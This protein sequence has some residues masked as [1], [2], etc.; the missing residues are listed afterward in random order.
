MSRK[1]FI[2]GAI[3]LMAA[4]LVVRLLGFV[5]RIYLSNLIGAEGM[6]IF[7]LISPVYS[8]VILTLTA[9][10]SI[11]VSRMVSAELARGHQVNLRRVAYC[12]LVIVGI[13]GLFTAALIYF[14]LD[15]LVNHVI[16]DRRTY[17]SFLLLIPCIPVIACASALKGYFY[18]IGSVVP[19]AVS[20]I[21]EQI[22]KIGFVML[23]AGYFVNAGLEY[24]CAIATVGMAFGE[25]S[26]LAVLAIVYAAGRNRKTD[27]K[28]E[29]GLMRKRKIVIE[30]VKTSVPVS[31]NR[32]VVS[33]MSA[34]ENILIPAM[35]LTGGLDY[36]SS[37]EVYGRLTGMAMP[38]IFFPALV[39]SSL[40]TTLVPAIAEA[41]SLRDFKTA[42]YRIS[43]CIQITFVLGFIFTA[44]FMSYPNE[45]GNLI[46]RREKIG[47]LLQVLSY[48][49]VLI[50]LQQ[51]LTGVLNGLGKQG[52]LLANTLVGS[53]IRIAFVYFLIP[54]YGIKSYVW[55]IAVS[56]F[57]TDILNLFAVTKVTGLLLNVR[58][59]LLGPA[60]VGIFMI[61][62]GRYI[63]YL[64]DIFV[65]SSIII[66]LLSLASSIVIGMLLMIAVGAVDFKDLK[67]KNR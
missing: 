45:I 12:A 1:S 21:V 16:K 9:G 18:G 23:M 33:I 63:Y 56:F 48:T 47:D 62:I 53:A 59:W 40:A 10:I 61:I 29:T 4:G 43:K 49:C 32:F 3:I 31:A 5:Y 19:T 51:I 22:V 54:V 34:V 30:L 57:V 55:G 15:V 64:F 6:G 39:T 41:L 50:Y 36:K 66:T 7:Q 65:E 14:N 25:I 8:L 24:A 46:Y 11:A 38:L 13:A 28:S 27:R 37:I 52:T 35:L 42:N 67:L 44:I 2:N 58:K 60:V 20:Q 17:Y 26:N